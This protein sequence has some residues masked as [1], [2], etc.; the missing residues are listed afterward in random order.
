MS[1][2]NRPGRP[3]PPA[4]ARAPART[5]PLP[6]LV[7]RPGYAWLVVGTVCI[8]AFMAALDASIVTIALPTVADSF[9]VGLNLAAWV[10][11]AYLLTLTALVVTFGRLADMFSRRTIYTAG[12]SVFIVGS[13]LSG[14]A[15]VFGFLLGARVLQAIGA[16]MLQANSVAIVT[17]AAPPGQRG[18]AI[19]LQAAA[20]AIGLALGPTIGGLLVGFLGWRAIF[21]VNV[22]VG[23]L[24]TL[25]GICLL[26]D[27]RRERAEQPA[28]TATK[29]GFDLGGAALLA[30]ALL[31][32][33]FGLTQGYKI[34]WLSPSVLAGFGVAVVGLIALVLV[35]RGARFPLVQPALL[36]VPI[37]VWGNLTGLLT[38]AA[39]FGV[40]FLMPFEF[41]R[42]F[43]LSPALSGILI[44]A[45]PL[46]MMLSSPLGG[47]LADRYGAH[48]LT[49]AGAILM[50]VGL[51]ALALVGGLGSPYLLLVPLAVVGVGMGLF[52]PPNNSSVMG[53]APPAFLGTAGGVLNMARSLGM[54]I[55]S[56]VAATLY[57]SFLLVYAGNEH[58]LATPSNLAACRDALIGF[59]LLTA[60]TVA[61]SVVKGDPGEPQAGAPAGERSLFVGEV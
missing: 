59:A 12:F 8:G 61:V 9:H 47:I 58:S 39:M 28:A 22:P 21:Y 32:M 36:K 20:Q 14:A 16:G 7:A 42:A 23:I 29:S 17:A 35:E 34:G 38:Y 43:R 27:D 57:A 55:G 10:T 40:L 3:S 26:P 54:S 30:V 6:A 46:A 19:G 48:K 44:T 60:V 18:R 5:F 53:S 50:E 11:I 45:V 41:E 33:M 31:G 51:V 52:T 24:G 37:F 56:A 15:P 49:V 4:G 1:Q 25:A 13:A 2:P